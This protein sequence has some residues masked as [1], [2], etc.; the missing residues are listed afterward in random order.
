MP[1][2]E[3]SQADGISR[4]AQAGTH[5]IDRHTGVDH[6][7][8]SIILFLR[9]WG[10][11]LSWRDAFEASYRGPAFGGIKCRPLSAGAVVTISADVLV[12]VFVTRARVRFDHHIPSIGGFAGNHSTTR[13]HIRERIINLRTSDRN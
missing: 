5:C 3:R 4:A 1:Q 2:Y 8:Q 11:T 7:Q 6:F 12:I 13:T 9:P 10:I